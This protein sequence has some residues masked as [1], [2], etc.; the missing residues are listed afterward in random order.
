[1]DK[2]SVIGIIIVALIFLGFTIYNSHQQK[3]YQEE[4]AAYNATQAEWQAEQDSIA[5]LNAPKEIQSLD[6]DGRKYS[7]GGFVVGSASCHAVRSVI[8]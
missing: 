2:K 6:G 5:A 1:M 4:L 7:C 3:K 8:G